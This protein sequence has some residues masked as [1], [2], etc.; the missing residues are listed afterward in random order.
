MPEDGLVDD[1]FPNATGITPPWLFPDCAI[2]P[3]NA[4][5]MGNSQEGN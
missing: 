1:S 4:V 2:T 3:I 5:Q